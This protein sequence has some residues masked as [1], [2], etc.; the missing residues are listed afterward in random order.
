[1]DRR[2]VALAAAAMAAVAVAWASAIA[3]CASAVAANW[4]CA[5]QS[6]AQHTQHI[7]PFHSA[8]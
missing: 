2:I 6:T 4:L 1:M 5:Q 7:V 3:A 8:A